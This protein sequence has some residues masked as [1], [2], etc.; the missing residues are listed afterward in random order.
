MAV[1][2]LTGQ[3]NV[4]PTLGRSAGDVFWRDLSEKMRPQKLAPFPSFHNWLKEKDP[5]WDWDSPFPR[6]L[7]EILDKITTGELRFVMIFGPPRH[8]KTELMT[9]RYPVYR[10]ERQAYLAKTNPKISPVFETIFGTYNLDHA[11]RVSRLARGFAERVYER[12]RRTVWGV[13]EWRTSEGGAFRASSVDS[14][15]TGTGA[16]FIII[17]DPIKGIEQ[18]SSQVYRDKIDEQFRDNYYSRLEP[19][20]AMMLSFARWSEDDL[21]GRLMLDEERREDWTVINF[22][23]IAETQEERDQWA[24]EEGMPIGLPDPLGREPGE[25]LWEARY[26]LSD[27]E[28]IRKNV[29]GF[30][31]LYQGHPHPRR[32]SVFQRDWFGDKFVD[33]ADVRRIQHRCIFVRYWDKAVSTDEGA[34]NSAGT[35]IALDKE[36]RIVYFIDCVAGQWGEFERESI[37]RATAE[38]DAATW[39]AANVR[40]DLEFWHE[41]EPGSGGLE[42]AQRTTRN[43]I[44]FRVF[45]ERPT[46]DKFIRALPLAAQCQSGNVRLVRGAWNA[47]WMNEFCAFRRGVA[48]KK[49]RVDSGSGAFGRVSRYIVAS[50]KKGSRSVSGVM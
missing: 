35:L 2:I 6:K 28:R 26:D 30:D 16:Q 32:G 15:V 34:C 49:D 22:P 13:K 38:M 41:Q 7:I 19:G 31:G 24:K 36:T 5:T 14:G 18:A 42:S 46:G 3:S 20:G 10:M 44:G 12:E 23:A 45:A 37:I 39:A 25:V 47:P 43:L 4:F 48:G 1:N 27:L 17:D 29:G 40:G 21:A 33:V 50:R 8:G 9:V 11:N